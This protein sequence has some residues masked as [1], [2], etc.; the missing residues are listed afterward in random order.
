MN[1]NT[2]DISAPIAILVTFWPA[3]GFVW[4]YFGKYSISTY[5]STVGNKL[6]PLGV[7]LTQFI[8]SSN[9]VS[10]SKLESSDNNNL[11]NLYFAYCL[12]GKWLIVILPLSS[13]LAMMVYT[14]FVLSIVNGNLVP[15]DLFVTGTAV[16]AIVL[17]V[18]MVIFIFLEILR[19]RIAEI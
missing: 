1:V 12:I 15:K 3:V 19:L 7:E 13:T 8:I 17:F 14:L 11:L 9:S 6:I 4:H 10:I 16:L 5:T 18:E 2:I